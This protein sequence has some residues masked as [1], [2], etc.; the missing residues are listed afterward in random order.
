MILDAKTDGVKNGEEEKKRE[1]SKKEDVCR[2]R[3]E[4]RVK[5]RCCQIFPDKI[6]IPPE[7]F[8]HYFYSNFQNFEQK[9]KI[10]KAQFRRS[11]RKL[12]L[13]NF[14]RCLDAT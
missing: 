13:T 7:S 4:R 8:D 14:F 12:Y 10:S 3:K 9:F 1:K 11:L 5:I 6:C 2:G